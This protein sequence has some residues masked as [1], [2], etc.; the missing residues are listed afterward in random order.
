MNV[1]DLIGLGIAIV[2]VAIAYLKWKLQYWEKIGLPTLNPRV[3]FG[4]TK[5]LM[6]GQCTFGEQF[7]QFYKQFKAKG[8]KHGGVYMGPKPFYVPIDTEIIKHIMQKDFQHFVNHG[9]F[10]D[11]NNDPL[12]GHLFNLEDAKWKNMRIKLTPTFTSGKMKMMFQT[13][14]DCTV[15]LKAIMDKSALN[16]IPVDIKDILGRFT[17]DIIGSVAF[18]LQC[19]SLKD[20]DAVFRKYGKKVFE[21]DGW[22]RLKL[23]LQFALPHQF[24][25]AIK[26]KATKSDVEKFFMKAVKDTVAYREKNNIYRKDFMHLLI[27]LK[28][29]GTITD[30]EKITDENGKIEEK[31]LTINEL[32]AQAFVFFLAG[33][34]TSSTTMTFAL[35]ELATNPHIQDKLRQEINSVLARHN[36]KLTY[37]GM[38]E[39]TYMDK[40][41]NETLRK[42][43]PV[44]LLIRKCNKDYIIPNTSIVIKKGID[45]GIPALGLHKDPQ[46][47]PNPELFDPER[48]SEENKNTRPSFTWLPFG[49]GPRACIDDRLHRLDCFGRHWNFY[50]HLSSAHRV[51]EM[52]IY[53]M[54]KNW[55]PNSTPKNI[56]LYQF[57]DENKVRLSTFQ[58]LV[59]I[60]IQN[61]TLNRKRSILDDFPKK[62]KNSRP[63]IWLPFGE[64]PKHCIGAMS[65]LVLVVVTA[66][67]KWKL[68]Y[69]NK[70]GLPTLNPVLFFGNIKQLL[71]GRQTFGEQFQEIYKEI[72]AK[73]LQ[74]AG[75]YFGVTPFYVP[76]DPEIIKHILQTDF[77]H[78]VNHGVFIDERHDPLSGHLFNLEGAK[79]K[80]MR[81]KLTPTFTSGKMKMMFQTLVDCTVGLKA[82]M[83]ES[84]TNDTPVDIKDTL[85]RF[86][87]DIIGSVAFGL[88]CNSLKDPNSLFRKYG[89]KVFEDNAWD[90]IK[91]SLQF[92]VPRGVLKILKFKMTK[93]DVEKFFMKV[94]S[95]TVNYREQNN[96]YRKDFMHLLLQLKNRGAIVDDEK[97]TDERGKIEEKALTMNELAAQAFVFFIA[98]FETSSTTLTFALYELATHPDIQEKLRQEINSVL[99]KHDNQ[100]TYNGVMEMT[101]MDKVLNETLRKYPPV[102]ILVRRCT[103]DYTIP[104]TMVRIKEGVNVSIPVLGLHRDPE[105]YPDPEVFDPERFSEKSKNARPTTVWIPFGQGPRTCIG[106]V[107]AILIGIIAYLKWKLTYWDKTGLPTLN[108]VILF[109]DT[110]D[111]LLG[112]STFSEQILQFYKTFKARGFRHGGVYVGSRPFYIPVDPE[113]IKHIMQVDFQHFVNHGNYIDEENDPLTGHLFNLEDAKWKNMRVKLTPTFTSGKMKMM[114]QTL[115][116]CSVE[117][118]SIIDNSANDNTPIEIKEILG[119]FTTDIIGSVAFG[120]ECNSLKDPDALFRKYGRKVFQG[121]RW[122]KFR[123]Y[124]QFLLPR[125]V[126]KVLKFKMTKPD[127]EKFFMKIIEETVTYREK[128]NI[129]RKDFMHLLL[130]LKNRGAVADDDKITDDQGN[131]QVEALTMNQLAAQA[132]VFFIA[133]FETSSTTMT[134]ALYEL[135]VNPNIQ[136]KLRHE[137]KRI[138][139][140]YDNQLTYN[141]IMEM[142]YMDQVPTLLY[143][144]LVYIRILNIIP[145][146]KILIL[147]DSPTKTKELDLHLP[148]FHLVKD[149]EYVLVYD[150]ACYKLKLA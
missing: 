21:M 17:T 89:K 32:A 36:D 44:P 137:I 12:S 74:H 124:L 57:R 18:G 129:S 38:M 136:E 66:Y 121:D 126:L 49:E 53:T 134:F 35:Y 92:I 123:A 28:N 31:A 80:N 1:L 30:D 48:F 77:Q 107:T 97:I 111:M 87:T 118:R 78:F 72:R 85:G 115:V 64:A 143:P 43:P 130:Q 20:P 140:K 2:V 50:S 88:E 27:Q 23:L 62:V 56:R 8:L 103:K 61:I 75:I 108:P 52:V 93:S 139:E 120:I 7:E 63:F 15:G 3:P 114:F 11:E 105:Y 116:D 132:Y 138:L 68:S 39:M 26:L 34:E 148:G 40:V 113:I 109:G 54:R 147:N 117:L 70:V 112:K 149:Q 95:E 46:Y 51:R 84:A 41:I 150:L 102:A 146:Q 100:L 22:E 33:F 110:K 45:V 13:L 133:G 42:Y 106:I 10:M 47:Y 119:R 90:R 4:D 14:A 91:A 6:L 19:N 144:R 142:T 59:Y 79:W 127:V 96:I 131:G 58:F 83:D 25:R 55:T 104:H 101:Y 9:S 60:T 99:K 141:A 29:R 67:L 16:N 86:G 69:W 125:Y 73:Q 81:I 145:I 122:D 98:G 71:L 82:I 37:D 135:A 24:L 5:Q 76:V 94:V 65:A 128:N